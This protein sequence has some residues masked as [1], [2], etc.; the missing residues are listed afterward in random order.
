MRGPWLA[1]HGSTLAGLALFAASGEIDLRIG[2][3]PRE[4]AEKASGNWLQR[5]IAAFRTQY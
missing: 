3:G 1:H 2:F 4:T 5:L